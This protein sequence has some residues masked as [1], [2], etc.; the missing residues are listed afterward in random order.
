MP[1]VSEEYAGRG[2]DSERRKNKPTPLLCSRGLLSPAFLSARRPPR[3]GRNEI[4]RYRVRHPHLRPTTPNPLPSALI[5]HVPV[6]AVRWGEALRLR[7]TDDIAR[8][9]GVS[10]TAEPKNRH[11]SNNNNNNVYRTVTGGCGGG[12]HGRFGR[13]R[14]IKRA[15]KTRVLYSIFAPSTRR[16]NKS[17]I[18]I[19]LFVLEYKIRLLLL[20]RICRSF[21]VGET[22]R[23]VLSLRFKLPDG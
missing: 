20:K 12:G 1:A 6:G 3:S 15:K 8:R 18:K 13:N 7:P 17:L 2:G 19:P 21:N 23:S 14:N 11:S 16:R 5:R 10:Q 9:P 4:F 22:G